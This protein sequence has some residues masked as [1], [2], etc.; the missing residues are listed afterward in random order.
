M[1]NG[2]NLEPL[3]YRFTE[4]LEGSLYN[5]DVILLSIFNKERVNL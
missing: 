5:R 4:D 3:I 1:I 2:R